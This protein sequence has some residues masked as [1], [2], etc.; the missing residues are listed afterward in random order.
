MSD[1]PYSFCVLIPVYNHPDKIEYIVNY[2]VKQKMP[3]LLVDDGS[4]FTCAQHIKKIAE[5]YEGVELSRLDRN[6]G[7]GAAVCHGL[8]LLYSKR[9]THALQIDAD[10]QHDINDIKSFLALSNKYPNAVISAF[11]PYEQMPTGRA[12]GRKITDFWVRVN[13]LSN[14][15]KDSMCGFRLYPLVIS[16]KVIS[17]YK[18]AKRMAFD[19]DIMVKL[20]WEGVDV[21]HIVSNVT[22]NDNAVSHFL[23]FRDNLGITLMHTQAFFGMLRRFLPLVRRYLCTRS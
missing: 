7:K 21:K 20:Y 22:Y 11:R 13:T 17:R 23:L 9:F 14:T 15:I 2:L 8:K 16:N 18:I 4:D 6:Q 12:R 10:G 1:E 19:T 5:S 3:V